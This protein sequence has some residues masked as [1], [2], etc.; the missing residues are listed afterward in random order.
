M[1]AEDYANLYA[2]EQ[3]FWW[4][5]GMREITA[6]LLDAACAPAE[7][8]LVLDA[9][10]GTG[11][12][13]TWLARYAGSGRVM[14]VDLAPDALRFCAERKHRGLAQASVTD[15]PFADST[16]DLVTSFDVLVQLPGEAA[17][18]RAMREMYR[19]LRPG[20]VAFLRVAAYRW[21]TSGHDRALG[22][23]RRYT[24]GELVG[25]VERAGFKTLRATY[26]NS[27]L[28]PVAAFRR[29]LL[30]RAGLADRG[31]DVK[32]L[33]PSLRWLNRALEGV[34][35]GEASILQGSRLRLPFGL[36]AICVAERPRR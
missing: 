26:A 21:M 30:K 19:V 4:F 7:S 15:L 17:D 18:E 23:Q 12:N 2:L 5:A 8:R 13:L 29:L 1:K 27:L 33:P 35:R 16:F 24:L 20:G 31:S 32:P 11:G 34:L 10:C 36:S 9:G 3:D 22:T 28:L 14:G 25:K 6:A